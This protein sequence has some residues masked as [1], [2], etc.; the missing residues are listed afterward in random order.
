MH[1]SSLRSGTAIN[2]ARYEFYNPLLPTQT[3]SVSSG[4]LT[5]I[6]ILANTNSVQIGARPLDNQVADGGQ[7]VQLALNNQGTNY[8]IGSSNSATVTIA[9]NEPVVSVATISNASRPSTPGIFR[10]TYPGVPAGQSL[11]HLVV[12]KFTLAG[13]T[14]NVDFQSASTVTFQPGSRSTDLTINPTSSGTAANLTV[15]I[16]PDTA[17]HVSTITPAATMSFVEADP[18]T[19]VSDNKTTP[20]AVSS[21][22]SSG[23]GCGLGSG[24]AAFILLGL[25]GLFAGLR[26]R[27]S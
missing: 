11:S 12:V 2:G 10:F 17:Y 21:G 4:Q 18:E 26:R 27:Q 9:D 22:A 20:G 24:V 19:G 6:R 14:Q 15:T 1:D 8:A 16:T 7:S 3:Y 23:G 5:Q 25:F 13:G